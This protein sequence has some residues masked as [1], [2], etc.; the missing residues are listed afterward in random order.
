MGRNHASG[1]DRVAVQVGQIIP[2]SDRDRADREK[3]APA[4]AGTSI[5]VRSDNATV[6]QQADVITGDLTIRM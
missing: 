1:N 5:N 2:A 3:P 6:G 4:A